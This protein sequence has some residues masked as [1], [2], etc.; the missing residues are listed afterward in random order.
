MYVRRLAT[1][2]QP[3]H[4]PKQLIA[5]AYATQVFM[6]VEHAAGDCWMADNHTSANNKLSEQT[7][8]G[9]ITHTHQWQISLSINYSPIPTTFLN[10]DD[11]LASLSKCKGC[12]AISTWLVSS[13]TQSKMRQK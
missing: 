8:T 11:Q 4:S 1:D 10:V 3:T 2:C 7:H 12:W 6:R 9:L 5:I 13:P